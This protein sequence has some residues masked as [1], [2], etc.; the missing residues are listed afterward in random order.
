MYKFIFKG[1]LKGFK[2]SKYKNLGSKRANMES[3]TIV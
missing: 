2:Y 3:E 1:K